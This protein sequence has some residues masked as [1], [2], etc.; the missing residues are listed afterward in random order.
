MVNQNKQRIEAL[1]GT[2][3]LAALVIVLQLISTYVPMPGGFSFTL[4]LTPI[5]LGAILYGPWA[6]AL[7]GAV[8]GIFV[9]ICTILGYPPLLYG[10]AHMMFEKLPVL[11]VALCLIK[12]SAAGFLSGLVYL[13]FRKG[14]KTLLGVFLASAVCPLVNTFLFCAALL[15]FYRDIAT[16]WMGSAYSNLFI[17]VILG[18]VG[19]NFVIEF[20]SNLIL[21]PGIERVI[22]AVRKRH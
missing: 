15:L 18:I 3:V 14:K 9:A 5:I 20:L 7:L 16:E 4:A 1:V 2:A 12:S 11:T 17:Y 13:P 8:L 21:A 10:G 6:G 19:V 22:Y